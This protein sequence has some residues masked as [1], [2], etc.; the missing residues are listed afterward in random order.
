MVDKAIARETAR[1]SLTYSIPL[2]DSFVAATAKLLGSDAV[3]TADSDFKLL[4]KK[5]Y[6]KSKAW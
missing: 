4:D 3:L 1:V 2:V 5:K 6:V